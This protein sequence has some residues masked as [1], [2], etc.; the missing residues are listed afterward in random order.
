MIVFFCRVL[1]LWA[2]G[3]STAASVM[4]KAAL[5][6]RAKEVDSKADQIQLEQGTETPFFLVMHSRLGIP[7][8][9]VDGLH[10]DHTPDIDARGTGPPLH[11]VR[12]WAVDES[13]VLPPAF[14]KSGAWAAEQQLSYVLGMGLCPWRSYLCL[15]V[16]GGGEADRQGMVTLWHGP[17]PS[18]AVR[19]LAE[20]LADP[21]TS[22]LL[23][24]LSKAYASQGQVLRFNPP[25]TM[26]KEHSGKSE[27]KNAGT[28]NGSISA[29]GHK[30]REREEGERER[31]K[32]FLA[33]L[34]KARGIQEGSLSPR[35]CRSPPAGGGKPL[36]LSGLLE[37]TSMDQGGGTGGR[38]ERPKPRRQRPVRLFVVSGLARS[39][40]AMFV[41]EIGAGE[42]FRQCDLCQHESYVLDGGGSEVFV[43]HG[44]S[45]KPSNQSLAVDVAVQYVKVL[46]LRRSATV[47]VSQVN[48][49]H[50][51]PSFT[52]CFR[53][54]DMALLPQSKD[55]TPSSCPSPTL[56]LTPTLSSNNSTPSPSLSISIGIPTSP[57]GSETLTS[58]VSASLACPLSLTQVNGADVGNNGT[59][60]GSDAP[61]PLLKSSSRLGSIFIPRVLRAASPFADPS[62]DSTTVQ[63]KGLLVSA[64][65]TSMARGGVGE[66][67]ADFRAIYDERGEILHQE[68]APRSSPKASSR[69]SALMGRFETKPGSK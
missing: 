1:Y 24:F 60:A 7:V 56:S 46:H 26:G 38:M 19:R 34:G 33:L 55:S 62:P 59:G 36:G 68:M 57:P 3:G 37:D 14:G 23:C 50:E 9:L 29:G 42:V 67:I 8:L 5:A 25:N 6:L 52:W 47:Q 20:D 69:I 18:Q 12:V 64:P 48:S 40:G 2:G 43:W 61:P 66:G 35:P 30:E 32:A 11:D 65:G 41:R 49:G 10:T 44:I 21:A 17:E 16:K 31:E 15:V 13:T 54:W 28:S 22:R 45:S 39:T 27:E 63:G 51:P 4:A 53:Q 58:P